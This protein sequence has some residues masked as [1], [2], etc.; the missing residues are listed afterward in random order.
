MAPRRHHLLGPAY[1]I[2]V[3]C[4]ASS[5]PTALYAE[6]ART[7]HLS[8]LAVTS[9]FAVYVTAVI[10]TML[11]CGGSSDVWGRRRVA[12]C[13]LALSALASGLF[14]SAVTPVALYA[15]RL[16]QGAA[17]GLVTG[18]ATAA[19][20]DG[21]QSARATGGA[22]TGAGGAGPE[23]RTGR[24]RRV[25][26]GSA[27]SLASLAISLGSAGGPL[28]SGLVAAA[29]P[30]PLVYPFLVNLVLL[31][32]TL[33]LPWPPG[34]SGERTS[35][36]PRRPTI[37]RRARR[38]F[39]GVAVTTVFSWSLLGLFLALIPSV[40]RE[41]DGGSGT[42]LGGAIVALMLTAS[43]LTQ[44]WAK[45]MAAGR[46]QLTGLAV[47][48]VGLT[49]LAVAAHL[50]SLP[51]LLVAAVAAG[52]G[53][54]LGF[55]GALTDLAAVTPPGVRAE[56]LSA[57]Y[58]IGYLALSVPVLGVG[59]AASR[60]GLLPAV[61]GFGAL[62]APGCLIAFCVVRRLNTG[63][64]VGAA[65]AAGTGSSAGGGSR[66]AGRAPTLRATGRNGEP[67]R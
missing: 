48:P 53:Q 27:V 14:A 66:S 1:T 25:G 28:M 18:A 65:A 62:G 39:T 11:L 19:L 9:L 5:V 37:P 60:A 55:A 67:S 41:L 23:P 26:R 6:Y 47:M 7:Y 49:G 43:A 15:G 50:G 12:G 20:A 61:I 10:P 13:G 21:E 34:V 24:P 64:P 51:L 17:A 38:T 31:L 32:P 58:V 56:V 4:A 35:W 16:L 42:A 63:A 40:T 33:L 54:G 36:R 2:A 45:R 3:I 29:S 59:A 52:V 44:P 22:R 8:P 46:G 30:A 57:A